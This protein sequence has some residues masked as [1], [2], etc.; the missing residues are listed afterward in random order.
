MSKGKSAPAVLLPHEAKQTLPTYFVLNAMATS[1]Y[2]NQFM[3]DLD[4][5]CTIIFLYGSASYSCAQFSYA[6]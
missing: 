3:R 1:T 6:L 5:Q 4:K 2:H